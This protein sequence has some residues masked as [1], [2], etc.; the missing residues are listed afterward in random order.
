[1]KRRLI[2]NTYSS[3]FNQLIILICGLILPGFL[4]RYY[5][6]EINGLV[7]SITRFINFISFMEL[8]M[9][10][11]VQSSLYKPLAK[12]DKNKISMIMKSAD[13][14]FKN[15][16]KVFLIYLCFVSILYPMFVDSN[17]GF[18]YTTSLIIILS[19][20]M[21]AQYYFGLV[22][23]LLVIADQKAYVCYFVNGLTIIGNTIVSILLIKYFNAN[24]HIVKLFSSLVYLGRPIYLYYYVKK[25]YN[26]DKNIEIVGEPIKQKWNGIAQH[27]S[28]IVLNNTDSII[29]SIFSNLSDVSIYSIYHMVVASINN[30][31]NSLTAGFQSLLGNMIAINKL[32]NANKLFDQ[33]EWIMHNAI[34]C[35]FSCTGLLIVPFVSVYT[36]GINDANYMQPIFALL[37]TL[38]QAFYC[39]RTTYYCAI[40]A[41]GHYQETQI[42]AIIEMT[43]NIIISVMA[44]R[45]YGLIGVTVGTLIAI[46]YRT[47]YCVIYTSKFILKRPI[48]KF[49]RQCLVDLLMVLIILFISQFIQITVNS[50]L[51]WFI[52]AT[53]IFIVSIMVILIINFL[54]Y[55]KELL[56]ITNKILKKIKL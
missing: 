25:N 37:L 23:Q 53:L 24:I 56:N 3:F 36:R 40:K 44:V 18:I 14:F 16:S 26:I 4:L 38:G 32:Y 39:L 8:G 30:I 50:Y 35:L 41:A 11:V 2:L 7:D 20:S 47:M 22:N 29:L 52:M 43:L 6:S 9:G 13:S 33:F 1:M 10:T 42:S 54:F 28:A 34:V 5:G 31:I 49:I 45:K 19:I 12:N 27:I 15:I 55:K 17:F 48:R 51:S 46:I 21:F